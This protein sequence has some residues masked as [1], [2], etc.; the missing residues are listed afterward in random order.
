MLIRALEPR[1]G[2]EAMAGRRG[3][4][5]IADLCSGPAKLTQA[6]GVGLDANGA[7]LLAAPFEVRAP[8]PGSAP[9][10]IVAGPRIGIS[11]AAE[12]PWR[13]CAADSPFLSRPAGPVASRRRRRRR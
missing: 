2:I 5:G 7:S 11:R 3:R 1:H 9:P 8:A 12:L 6:L 13:F 10:E 4:P